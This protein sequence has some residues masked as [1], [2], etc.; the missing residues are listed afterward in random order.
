MCSSL[1]GVESDISEPLGIERVVRRL[2]AGVV[3]VLAGVAGD[4]LGVVP[5]GLEGRRVDGSAAREGTAWAGTVLDEDGK[6]V[7][8]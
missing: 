5:W 2:R 3:E 8:N 7:A 6:A 4:A 1:H